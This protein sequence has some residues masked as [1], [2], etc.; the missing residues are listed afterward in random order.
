MISQLRQTCYAITLCF[1]LA[2]CQSNQ[3]A[4]VSPPP[5]PTQTTVQIPAQTQTNNPQKAPSQDNIKELK[6]A[7]ATVVDLSLSKELLEKIDADSQRELNLELQEKIVNETAE[8]RKMK[9][10]G[11]VFVDKNEQDLTRKVDGGEVKFSVPF[12]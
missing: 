7:A 9:I 1:L 6:P 8:Q 10:S 4:S 3:E 2:S 11:G 5:S 12:N